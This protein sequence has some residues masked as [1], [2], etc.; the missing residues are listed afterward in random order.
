M[1][2]GRTAAQGGVESWLV[3][4]STAALPLLRSTSRIS[5]LVSYTFRDKQ[6]TSTAYSRFW[7][8]FGAICAP[9]N[10]SIFGSDLVRKWQKNFDQVD[11]RFFRKFPV[12]TL[13]F[14]RFLRA[15]EVGWLV[16]RTSHSGV[17]KLVG[18]WGSHRTVR[19]GGCNLV[20]THNPGR[21]GLCV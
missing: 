3:G 8:S 15:P 16:G 12:V 7:P 1:V 6:W 11:P 5:N 10:R 2:G 14:C 18:W 19:G 17:R 21:P 9:K 13:D 4:S 20:K